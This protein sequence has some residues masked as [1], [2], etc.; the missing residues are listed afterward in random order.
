MD[1]GLYGC[2]AALVWVLQRHNLAVPHHVTKHRR[3]GRCYRR[4]L[5]V[6]RSSFVGLGMAV[7]CVAVARLAASM[8]PDMQGAV[9]YLTGVGAALAL[10]VTVEAAV[11]TLRRAVSREAARSAAR[12]ERAR[13]IR[14]MMRLGLG[15]RSEQ[16]F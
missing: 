5:A 11:L 7:F 13:S 1:P 14:T 6:T 2:I 10:L 8:L 12:R 9:L 16:L 15:P 4:V 3:L